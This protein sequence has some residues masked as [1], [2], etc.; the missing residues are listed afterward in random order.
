MDQH[1]TLEHKINAIERRMKRLERQMLWANIIGTIRLVVLVVPI[2]LALIFVPP[3]VKEYAPF[4]ADAISM[5]QQVGDQ[6]R[7]VR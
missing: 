5:L 2:V 3:F 4:I 6:I 7:S 1:E